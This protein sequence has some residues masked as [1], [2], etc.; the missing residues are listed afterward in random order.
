MCPQEVHVA[1]SRINN[2]CF[3][4]RINVDTCMYVHISLFSYYASLGLLTNL[5]L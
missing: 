1:N 3:I 2:S 4:Q 5:I